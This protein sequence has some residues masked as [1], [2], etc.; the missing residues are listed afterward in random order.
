MNKMIQVKKQWKKYCKTY[1]NIPYDKFWL[2][3]YP[4]I[5]WEPANTR[6]QAIIKYLKKNDTIL[7]AGCG[8]GWIS[9]SLI[10]QGYKNVTSVDLSQ[11]SILYSSRIGNITK[12]KFNLIKADLTNLPFNDCSFSVICS[13]EVL[14]HIQK[15]DKA[16]TE[17][18][19]VL[20]KKGILII[21]IPNKYGC[22][23]LMEDSFSKIIHKQHQG[24]EEKHV[25][26]HTFNWWNKVFTKNNFEVIDTYNVEFLSPF[27]AVFGR[28]LVKK[29]VML[30]SKLSKYV[31]KIFASGWIFVLKN[32]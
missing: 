10:N 13:M 26:L 23:S 32:K 20:Y 14:E 6:L 25:Q 5:N 11:K 30:D 17:L 7:D 21:S 29:L 18:K 15:L 31:P 1:G 8:K 22:F 28:K 3:Y 4:W 27:F 24:I 9:L 19:R 12:S 16:L 2:E